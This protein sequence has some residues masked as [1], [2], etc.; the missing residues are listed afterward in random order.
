MTNA[1]ESGDVLAGKYRVEHVLGV[2]GM[3]MV[4]AARHLQLDSLVALKFMLDEAAENPENV[5]RFLREARAAA[6][7]KGEHVARVMDVGT[8]ESGAPY[9]VME[10][11]EG[12]DLGA[13]LSS[14][15][16]PSVP[17]AVEYI[18]QACEAIEEAHGRGIIHRDIKP[19]NLFLTR[20]PN[21]QPCVKVLDFGISKLAAADGATTGQIKATNTTAVFGSPL[22][23]APEQMRSSTKVDV[24]ADVWALGA[25]LYELLA[26]HVPFPAESMMEL[27]LKVAQDAPEPIAPLNPDVPKELEAIVLRCLEKNPAD[28]FPTVAAFSVALA[29]YAIQRRVSIVGD[30]GA[31]ATHP[32]P[33]VA[34]TAALGPVGGAER[35]SG[36]PLAPATDPGDARPPPAR[37]AEGPPPG[38]TQRLSFS[39][40]AGRVSA[41]DAGPAAAPLAAAPAVSIAATGANWGS[42][43]SGAKTARSRRRTVS[44]LGSVLVVGSLAVVVV[45]ATRRGSSPQASGAGAT[46][47]SSVV[48]AAVVPEAVVPE[49]LPSAPLAAP[50]ATV[51]PLPAASTSAV[52]TAVAL[53]SH[54]LSPFAAPPIKPG[55]GAAATAAARVTPSAAPPPKA[56]PSSRSARDPYMNPN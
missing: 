22:Y 37:D 19:S 27:C 33:A 40:G 30:S 32:V 41:P 36:S 47:S 4:V 16:R 12:K 20:R 31:A 15:G 7:L 51:A 24:R 17:E 50:S 46:L 2:G 1:V 34:V 35:G 14:G 45:L 5:S 28:R 13:V 43:R 26:A 48:P 56:A 55:T 53:P 6:R 8:L 49:P 21:G 42:T 29:P 9:M 52:A 3:G 10:H 25:T 18:L 39:D 44:L 54:T 38:A 23:M 11:L